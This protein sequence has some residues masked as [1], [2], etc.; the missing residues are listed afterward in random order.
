MIERLETPVSWK[1]APRGALVLNGAHGSLEIARSLGRRGIRVWLITDDNPLAKSSRYVERSFTWA[2]PRDDSALGFLTEL[3]RRHDLHGW[4][5]FAGSDDDLCFIAQNHP[6]LAGLFTLTTPPWETVRFAYDKQ[7]MNIRAAELG[8]AHPRTHYP[9][10]A[11]DLTNS[12]LSFPVILKPSVREGRNAFVDAKAWRAD[13]PHELAARYKAAA[14]L[15]AA[16]TIM[17]QELIP[18]DGTAQY[19]YAAIWDRGA[20]VGALVARRRRQYPVEFGFTST[21]VE[22]ADAPE[23]V[24]AAACF[25]DSINYS[26]L[27]E[28]EFKYDARDG[29]YKILDVNARAWTWIA[30]GAAA[31]IDFPALQWALA[32]GEVIAPRAV[33]NGA[34]WLYFPRDLA[35][36]LQEMAAGT[37]SP[38][39]YLRSLNRSSAC[40]V[41]ALDDPWPA[42][43]DIPLSAARVVKRRLSRRNRAAAAALES[44]RLPS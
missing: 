40:A 10:T 4:V 28:I 18:G 13:H 38:L 44:A 19:S 5:L 30:L 21:F 12:E 39:A 7:Q 23:V 14:A 20:P 32:C 35:A 42:V 8:I 43:I 9:R 25:L 17:V 37:L 15:V 16:D 2:G 11:D 1:G 33:H 22:T 3:C 26:G 36:S 6:A 27:V 24:A 31:G 41:F 29:R 34:S